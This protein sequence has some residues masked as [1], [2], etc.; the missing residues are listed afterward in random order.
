ML[1]VVVVAAVADV[2]GSV[3]FVSVAFNEKLKVVQR[4][5]QHQHYQDWCNEES[6]EQHFHL[7]KPWVW[8]NKEAV[9][10]GWSTLQH[11]QDVNLGLYWLV[12]D[13][14]SFTK[15]ALRHQDSTSHLRA[16]RVQK[17]LDTRVALFSLTS[18]R[19]ERLTTMKY[20]I[21]K[22]RKAMGPT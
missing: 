19:A 6:Y 5:G 12:S 17:H 3:W 10:L 22:L 9:L 1:V 20:C 18:S 16:T 13:L 2:R 7:W 8:A 21:L 15:L 14:S 11:R 4:W